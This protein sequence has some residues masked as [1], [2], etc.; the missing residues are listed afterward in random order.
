M[1]EIMRNNI[2]LGLE[3]GA[4]L[5]DLEIKAGRAKRREWKH[6]CTRSIFRGSGQHCYAVRLQFTS[7]EA[8][9][10]VEERAGSDLLIRSIL[11]LNHSLRHRRCGSSSALSSSS[12]LSSS[13]VRCLVFVDLMR[14]RTP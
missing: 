1:T 2:R 6:V 13:S 11:D 7:S 9:V 12:S 14:F 10:L 5:D 4:N 3:R 8:K